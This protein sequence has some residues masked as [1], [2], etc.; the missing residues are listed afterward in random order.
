WKLSV[1][2]ELEYI[3]NATPFIPEGE[4]RGAPAH[5]CPS[6]DFIPLYN[7]VSLFSYTW[8]NSKHCVTTDKFSNNRKKPTNTLAD[9]GIEAETPCP[10]VALAT[11]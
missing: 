11:I 6:R 4:G 3:S 8:H 1:V 9:P 5:Y 2:I 10:T 7:G